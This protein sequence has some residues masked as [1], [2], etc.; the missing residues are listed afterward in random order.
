V[1][2]APV[3]AGAGGGATGAL[4][5]SLMV[6]AA[7]MTWGTWTLFLHPTGVPGIVSTPIVFATMA[8]TSLPLVRGEVAPTWGR[9][10]W[11]LI[12]ANAACDAL[13]V[14]CY[15]TA[16]DHTT[17]QVAVLSHY[18]TPILVALSAPW[19]DRVATPGARPAAVV[20]M[21][22]LAVVLEPWNAPAGGAVVGAALGLASAAAYAG[23]VFVV[24]R[25]VGRIGAAR[26]MALHAVGAAV[27]VLPLVAT[28]LAEVTPTALGWLVAGGIVPGTIAGVVFARG[29]ARIGSARAAVLTF[30]EPI[31]AVGCGVIA[32]HE[33]LHPAAAAGAVMILGAGVY[34]STRAR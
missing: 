29:L 25:L 3:R 6:I 16:L 9:T 33:Q 21:A 17:V 7:A 5:G 14:A 19:I 13:N 18:A 10:T 11:L 12:A 4:A 34:V 26:A 15:F 27:L 32:W 30:A 22:G 2:G 23:N 8:I 28:R 1:T 24:R 31:V 20:A